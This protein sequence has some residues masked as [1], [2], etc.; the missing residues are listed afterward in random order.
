MAK[1]AHNDY[2]EQAS[3]SGLIGLALYVALVFG[4]LH[5]LYRKRLPGMDFLR[6]TVWLGLVGWALHSSVEFPLY[7]P[8][9]AWTAFAFLGYLSGTGESE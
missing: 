5:Y 8:G 3:D 7:I 2:L 4:I 1:L 9:L 6:F